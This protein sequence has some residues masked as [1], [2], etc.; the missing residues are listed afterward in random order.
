MLAGN[1][2][3]AAANHHQLKLDCWSKLLMRRL[4]FWQEMETVTSKESVKLHVAVHQCDCGPNVNQVDETGWLVAQDPTMKTKLDKLSQWYPKIDFDTLQNV[5]A[6][7]EG[8]MH[9]TKQVGAHHAN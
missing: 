8:D 4:L 6:A 5:L 7:H 3:A 9:Q 1:S 2:C